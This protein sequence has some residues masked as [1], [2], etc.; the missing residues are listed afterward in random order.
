MYIK[1]P[2]IRSE[3]VHSIS[4]FQKLDRMMFIEVIPILF[5][6]HI[7]DP[8]LNQVVGKGIKIS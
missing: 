6:R 3:D 1:V 4:T 2:K 7:R 5:V 8:T